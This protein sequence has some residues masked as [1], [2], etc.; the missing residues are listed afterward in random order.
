MIPAFQPSLA[1]H[2]RSISSL[3]PRILADTNRD[4]VMDERDEAGKHDWASRRGAIFLPNIGDSAK[5]CPVT[6]S[7]G[8]PLSNRELAGFHDASG[9]RLLPSSVRYTV[10]LKTMRL[11]DVSD[12]AIGRICIEPAHHCDRVRLF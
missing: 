10:P 3:G 7:A 8:A 6:D 2:S 11:P 1:P 12:E 5:R 9:D 4:G